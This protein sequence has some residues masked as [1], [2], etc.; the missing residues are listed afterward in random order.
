MRL[1]VDAQ[2]F[3]ESEC[4]EA[5]SRH[6]TSAAKGNLDRMLSARQSYHFTSGM[7]AGTSSNTAN[8][9][10]Q[11]IGAAPKVF[12]NGGIAAPLRPVQRKAVQVRYGS[13]PSMPPPRLKKKKEKSDTISLLREGEVRTCATVTQPYK[14]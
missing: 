8:I 4:V 1:C 2:F 14:V 10:H 6:R 5:V 12:R 11:D 7:L 3:A 13:S 9:S